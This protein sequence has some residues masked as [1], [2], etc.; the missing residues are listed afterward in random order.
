MFSEKLS[1]A[2]QKNPTKY[3]YKMFFSNS[4][5][6]FDNKKNCISTNIAGANIQTWINM[7]IILKISAKLATPGLQK[8]YDVKIWAHD[9]TN[10]IFSCDSYYN[11]DVDI[12]RKFINSSISMNSSISIITPILQG[13][14]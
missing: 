2:G 1:Q 9:I 11:V 10:K 3:W 14:G 4:Y 6:D 8:G 12:W 13:F 5:C 7:I